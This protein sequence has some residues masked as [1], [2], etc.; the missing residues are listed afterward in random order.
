MLE[1]GSKNHFAGTKGRQKMFEF[2]ESIKNDPSFLEH[3]KSVAHKLRARVW[4]D[5]LQPHQRPIKHEGTSSR[6][7]SC[8]FASLIAIK[9]FL[10]EFMREG[11]T[12]NQHFH[13][14]SWN[15][16]QTGYTSVIKLISRTTGAMRLVTQRFLLFPSL[17]EF[18]SR[19]LLP[20]N[21]KLGH[22]DDWVRLWQL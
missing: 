20:K 3:D 19:F 8:W 10:K 21:W 5:T 16:S 17:P 13:P 4:N 1:N 11:W 15:T 6:S 2:L 12:I 14:S 22:S 18:L 9:S 7:K